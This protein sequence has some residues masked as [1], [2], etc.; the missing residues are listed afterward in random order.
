MHGVP[1]ACGMEHAK[2]LSLTGQV[3]L[4]HIKPLQHQQHGH[5]ALPG[6]QR[7]KSWEEVGAAAAAEAAAAAASASASAAAAAPRTAALPAPTA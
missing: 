4:A 7:V 1:Q 3:L 2:S 5:D 6:A